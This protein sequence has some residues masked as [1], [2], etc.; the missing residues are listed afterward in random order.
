MRHTAECGR[1]MLLVQGFL[2]WSLRRGPGDRGAGRHHFPQPGALRALAGGVLR[3]E[4]RHL[5]AHRGGVPRRRARARLRGRGDGAVLV[6]RDDAGHQHGVPAQR[7]HEGTRGW[8]GSP[9]A[10]V[11]AEI[12]GVVTASSMGLDVHQGAWPHRPT[13]YSNTTELGVALYTRFAYPF[14][15]A[16][17][18]LLVAIVAAISLT[19]RKRPNLEGSGL[20]HAGQRACAGPRAHHQDG[21][22]E[23]RATPRL[24]KRLRRSA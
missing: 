18:L 17:V 22:A 8:A 15:L 5:A 6:R 11:I 19:M 2:F 13:G 10:V 21:C 1:T 16:A 3:Y 14:E 23:R 20:L 9:A 24:Q 7:L 4:R 12:V